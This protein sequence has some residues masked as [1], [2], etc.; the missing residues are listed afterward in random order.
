MP[1]F[2]GATRGDLFMDVNEIHLKMLV[3]N[4]FNFLQWTDYSS[5]T[6]RGPIL[7][8]WR[9]MSMELGGLSAMMVGMTIG[10]QLFAA[11]E[12]TG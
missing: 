1:T 3:I 5:S 7:V 2:L 11:P 4:L 8:F 6:E 9:L 12:D 10:L